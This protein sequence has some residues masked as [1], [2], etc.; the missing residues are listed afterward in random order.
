MSDS[1]LDAE[2]HKLAGLRNSHFSYRNDFNWFDEAP[3]VRKN[4]HYYLFGNP[5][6]EKKMVCLRRA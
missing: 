6:L 4:L 2:I 1:G 5:E 3:R